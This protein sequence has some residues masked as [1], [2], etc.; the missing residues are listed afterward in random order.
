M[1]W[2]I[3]RYTAINLLSECGFN[4]MMKKEIVI[5]VYKI[6]HAIGKYCAGGVRGGFTRF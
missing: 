5:S 1:S 3:K 6:P 2:N 4:K